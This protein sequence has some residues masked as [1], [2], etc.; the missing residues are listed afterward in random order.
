[1]KAFIFLLIL[2]IGCTPIITTFNQDD[3]VSATFKD[4][5]GTKNQ[6]FTRSQEWLIA[7]FN[8]AESV[9]Q[10]SD[11]EDGV[12]IGKYKLRTVAT[13]GHGYDLYATITIQVKD[14]RARI[15][16]QPYGTWGY[17]KSSNLI[18]YTKEQARKEMEEMGW[19]FEQF[20]R[21]PMDF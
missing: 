4:L 5:E 11:K 10:Y 8:S 16:I 1:M 12:I 9:I 7:A 18:P 21:V 17:I 13:A 6:L 14:G 2:C 20:I 19:S 15:S 3:N